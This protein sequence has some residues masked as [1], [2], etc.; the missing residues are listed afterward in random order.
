MASVGVVFGTLALT[1]LVVDNNAGA[2]VVGS[3]VT[4]DGLPAAT[5][6]DSNGAFTLYLPL[7]PTT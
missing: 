5:A 4:V 2:P 7:E 3:T 1:G 6:T